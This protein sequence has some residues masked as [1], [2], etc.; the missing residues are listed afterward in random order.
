MAN[1]DPWRTLEPGNP[2]NALPLWMAIGFVIS[3]NDE[4][5]TIAERWRRRR[6]QEAGPA[7]EPEGT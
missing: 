5:F 1:E 2:D 3:H 6:A 4:E 7:S